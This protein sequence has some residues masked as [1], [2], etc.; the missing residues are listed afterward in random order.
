MGTLVVDIV[1]PAERR[2]WNQPVRAR[3]NQSH[4]QAKPRH[5]GDP[6]LELRPHPVGEEGGDIAVGGRALR[7]HGPAFGGGDQFGGDLQLRDVIF[8]KPIVAQAKGRDQPAMHDQVGIASDRRGEVSIARQ[9]EPKVPD[10]VGVIV[11]LHLSAQ[12]DLVDDLCVRSIAGLGQQRI[13]SLRARCLA[14]APGNRERGQEIHQALHLQGAGRVMD[15]IEQGTLLGL[16]SLGGT[17]IG[18][19]HDLLN[20]LVRLQRY[21][22]GDGADLAVGIDHN[23]PFSALDG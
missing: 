3:F 13:E 5:A 6:A 11:R 8:G 21:P 18:L 20:Q 1:L 19:H 10:V 17:D 14:L 12:H 9:V 7:R 16:Q 2:D 4:E 22:L 15:A 23:A